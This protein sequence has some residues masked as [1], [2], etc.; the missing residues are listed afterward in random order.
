MREP[1]V[2]RQRPRSLANLN[3]PY[4]LDRNVTIIWPEEKQSLNI[5]RNGQAHDMFHDDRVGTG[6]QR[7]RSRQTGDELET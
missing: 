1:P 7:F 5:S 6:G 4:F 3:Y 2:T